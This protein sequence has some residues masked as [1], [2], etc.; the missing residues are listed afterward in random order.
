MQYIKY[1]E[2]S[3]V[4]RDCPVSARSVGTALSQDQVATSVH[5]SWQSPDP[6]SGGNLNRNISLDVI[7]KASVFPI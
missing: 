3:P 2:G 5:I 4:C 1:S 6:G 7:R